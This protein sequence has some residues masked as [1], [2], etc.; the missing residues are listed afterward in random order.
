MKRDPATGEMKPAGLSYRPLLPSE[1]NQAALA[2]TKAADLEWGRA[3]GKASGQE[4]KHH[5]PDL[6]AL[7]A[8]SAQRVSE[9]NSS[10]MAAARRVTRSTHPMT[11]G[12]A[13]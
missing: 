9:P 4:V 2:F 8:R 12:T 6:V 11:R 13:R 10:R 3:G 5:F 1:L 7:I